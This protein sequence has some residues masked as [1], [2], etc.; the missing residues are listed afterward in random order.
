[1]I[2]SLFK[3]ALVA[4]NG[5]I[6]SEHALMYSF[7]LAKQMHISLKVVF[8]V[9]TATINHLALSKLFIADEKDYY[10]DNLISD[11]EKYLKY[12]EELAKAKGVL[13]ETE[14]R[15]GSVWSEVV[16]A[17]KEYE[18]DHIIIGGQEYKPAESIHRNVVS[19]TLSEII[20][21][22]HCSVLVV[23]QPEI[24]TLFNYL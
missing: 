16:K 2:K 7:I 1:M 22:S 12:V 11:G 21:S 17:A 24:E 9:D 18:A 8:V 3:K 13:V 14:L 19:S 15:K 20:A 4:V 6:Y 5:S 10:R 23:K